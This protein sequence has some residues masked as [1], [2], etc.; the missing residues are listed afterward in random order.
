[1]EDT[2]KAY[3]SGELKIVLANKKAEVG[4]NLQKGT[5]AIHHLT[6]PWTPASINQRNGRG[7]RQGDKIDSV[8]VYYYCG[9][10]TFDSYRK[11]L[12]KAKSNWIND[13]LMGEAKTMENGDVTGLER[14]ARYA[15]R[16]P[17]GSQK[18]CARS[19]S[20]H[21]GA[22]R[23]E[24]FRMGLIPNKMQVLASIQKNIDS[25]DQKKAARRGSPCRSNEILPAVRLPNMKR[26]LPTPL[27]LKMNVKRPRTNSPPPASLRLSEAETKDLSGLDENF[28]KIPRETRKPGK[29]ERGPA[30]TGRA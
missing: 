20:P 16:Q 4:V 5:T 7:V 1:M 26:N 27:S 12:L 8:A 22:K 24:N 18:E 2:S 15:G 30:P 19:A 23:E 10:G 17:R 21:K 14:I 6:L 29:Y 11:D 3:N 25:I 13:L 28:S 9:K